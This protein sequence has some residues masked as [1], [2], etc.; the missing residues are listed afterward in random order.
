[1]S[2][3]TAKILIALAAVASALT[4]LYFYLRRKDE[5]NL[6][7]FDDDFDDFDDYEE[8]D[9]EPA[10]K[11]GFFKKYFSL[12]R[13]DAE[14]VA[15][16]A[17]DAE[18]ADEADEAAEVAEAAEVKEEVKEEPKPEVKEEVK[19]EPKPEVKE[20][21]KEEPKPEVK[22][23]VKEEPKPEVKEE[24]KEEPKPEVKEEAK[25]VPEKKEPAPGESIHV[26]DF[27]DEEDEDSEYAQDLKKAQAAGEAAAAQASLNEVFITDGDGEEE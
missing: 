13:K 19:E 9:F 10:P 1:M 22:E 18:E 4:A 6:V 12:K 27:F 8:E 14:E 2:K 15:E 7:P 20:E 11:I 23:E 21:M 26:D 16:E 5:L 25:E 3:K 24:V 17:A